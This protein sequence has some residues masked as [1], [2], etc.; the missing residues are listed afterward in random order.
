MNHHKPEVFKNHTITVPS[1]EIK[2]TKEVMC[3]LLMHNFSYF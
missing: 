2:V 1:F 3:I